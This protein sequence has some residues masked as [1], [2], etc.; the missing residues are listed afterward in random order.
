MTVNDAFG[1]DLFTK[2]NTPGLFIVSLNI[3][4]HCKENL[5]YSEHVPRR[6]TQ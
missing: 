1:A 6:G 3:E 5:H 4:A 2:P